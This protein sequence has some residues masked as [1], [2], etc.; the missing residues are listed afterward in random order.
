LS[1][2]A[3]KMRA[4]WNRRAVEDAH[5]YVAFGRRDQTDEEFL[6]TATPVIRN[7]LDKE[8]KWIPRNA[9]WRS[10]RALEIGCGPGRLMVPMSRRFGE[11]HGVDVS[12]E[13]IRLAGERLR[14]I[15]NAHVHHTDGADLAEFANEFF[16][17]VYSYA[18]FQHIPDRQIVFNY[19]R[20]SCRVLKS[21]G[22]LRCQINGLPETATQYDTWHGARINAQEIIEFA[23]GNNLQLLALEG[24]NTQYMWVTARKKPIPRDERSAG[25][26]VHIRRITNAHTSE[27]LAP[28]HGRFASFSLWVEGL[29]PDCD[30]LDLEA[31]I[32]PRRI[33]PFYIGAPEH[34][35][36]QQINFTLPQTLGTGL[37]PIQL[38]RSGVPLCPQTTIRVVTPGPLVPRVIRVTDAVDLLSGTQIVSGYVKVILEE[39]ER[40]QELQASVDGHPVGGMEFFCTDPVPPRFEV[41]FAL[42]ESV[43]DGPHLLD[44]QLGR[45]RFAPVPIQVAWERKV[46]VVAPTQSFIEL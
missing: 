41:N 17:F 37:A 29:P 34:D 44:L 33:G 25:S 9:D 46:A 32:G 13:M 10:L 45:R 12:D 27:P 31:D 38:R 23:T 2:A 19:L 3:E 14:E 26:P 39:V 15:P 5:Y 28:C 4:D 42:P 8:L 35:G 11:I 1:E 43:E 30:L 18:V 40:P 36:L 22:L 7:H 21:G 24:R 16:D 6:V 20:E